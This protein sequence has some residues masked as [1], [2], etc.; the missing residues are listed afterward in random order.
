MCDNSN[1]QPTI[2]FTWNMTSITKWVIFT[3]PFKMI[4]SMTNETLKLV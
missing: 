1:F 3:I 4:I 2:T